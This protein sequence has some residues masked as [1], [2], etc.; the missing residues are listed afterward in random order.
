LGVAIALFFFLPYCQIVRGN[1]AVDYLV[2]KASA[3][4]KAWLAAIGNI[5]FTVIA[6]VLAWELFNGFLDRLGPYGETTWILGVPMKWGYLA[7]F[8]ASFLLA[9]VCA[10]TAV[11]SVGEAL[12][13][14]EPPP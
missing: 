10:Y 13:E 6:A 14:G 2:S 7:A 9:A 5:I 11:R 12:G 4:S 8:V 3:Q 1:V